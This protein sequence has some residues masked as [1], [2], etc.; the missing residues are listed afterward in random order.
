LDNGVFLEK[1][2]DRTREPLLCEH[3]P[4]HATCVTRFMT[5]TRALNFLE[6][7]ELPDSI[8]TSSIQFSVYDTHDIVLGI[9]K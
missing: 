8:S 6:K 5:L 3:Q 9:R 2:R 4:H 7:L 1:T